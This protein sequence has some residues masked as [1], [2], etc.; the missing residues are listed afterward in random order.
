MNSVIRFWNLN[1]KRIIIIGLIVVFFIFIIQLLNQI[2]KAQKN[3]TSR[4]NT[5]SIVVEEKLPTESIISGT[6]VSEKTTTNN[7][8][9]IDEF[10][11]NCNNA[12][13]EGAYNLLT[14]KCKEVLFPSQEI[15][16][17][18]YYD[19]IFK[20][21]RIYNI[22]N[23]IS[24]NKLN[25]YRIEYFSDVM[26][27]GKIK[28]EIDFQDYITIDEKENDKININSFIGYKEI[29]KKNEKKNDKIEIKVIGKQV[30]KEFELY[31]IEVQNKTDKTI[32]L[33]TQDKSNTILLKA[34]NTDYGAYLGDLS[35]KE[36][37]INANQNITYWVRFNKTYTSLN[38]MK[39]LNFTD[40]IED[41]ELYMQNKQNYKE[42]TSLVVNLQK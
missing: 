12:N 15:F 33:D 10:I 39:E 21:K 19:V 14:E 13:I 16:K 2:I 32:L 30:F 37:I 11:K 6:T 29:N 22:E 20:E 9:I 36:L 42:R 40:I 3:D 27:T 7:T 31:E 18:N 1:R 24:S 38:D 28:E 25:T 4:N 34:N 8:Q 5:N 23:W 35:A 17:L 41:Y 26:A